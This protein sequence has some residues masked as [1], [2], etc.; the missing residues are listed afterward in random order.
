[1]DTWGFIERG[2]VLLTIAICDDNRTDLHLMEKAVRRWASQ[3]PR[4]QIEIA[5]FEH[6][7]EL[8]QDVQM[9][10]R[11]SVWILDIVMPGIDGIRLAKK[12]RAYDTESSL[13]YATASKEFA[14]EAY[15][16]HALQ[17]LVKP[18]GDN[19]LFE[20]MNFIAKQNENKME[21]AIMVHQKDGI[22]RVLIKDLIYIEN[23]SRV[24]VYHLTAHRCVEGLKIRGNFNQAVTPIPTV[25]GFIS[26]HQSFWVNMQYIYSITQ[27]SIIL[28]NKEQIPISRNKYAMVRQSYLEYIAEKGGFIS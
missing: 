3:N 22:A 7:E 23:Q 5:L 16:N 2:D 6:P 25:Q 18:V 13:I 17:Y 26:P 4:I 12:L 19:A 28:E 1:M 10:K 20:V 9:G 27:D 21:L 14:L 24:P 15:E 8:L 11:Y